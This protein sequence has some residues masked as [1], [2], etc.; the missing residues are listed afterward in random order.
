MMH[1]RTRLDEGGTPRLERLGVDSETLRRDH[2]K[3]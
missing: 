2:V 1:L 3:S